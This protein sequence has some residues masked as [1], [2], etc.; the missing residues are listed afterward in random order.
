MQRKITLTINEGL[1]RDLH[2]LIGKRGISSFVEQSVKK[3]VK[4]LKLGDPLEEGYKM[5]GLDEKRE[6]EALEWTEAGIDENLK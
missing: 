2:L 3:R 5:M 6:K 4:E 1:Y